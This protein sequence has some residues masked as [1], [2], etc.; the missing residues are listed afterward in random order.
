MSDP[1]SKNAVK[2][3][4]D[5]D[6]EEPLQAYLAQ[7]PFWLEFPAAIEARFLLRG[8]PARLKRFLF[9]LRWS[10][11]V[12]TVMVL[13]D[14]LLLGTNKEW[15]FGLRLFALGSCA[16]GLLVLPRERFAAHRERSM[17]ALCVVMAVCQ[18][19]IVYAG[20]GMATQLYDGAL[21][22]V[23][24]LCN[25]VARVRLRQALP[26]TLMWWLLF[27]FQELFHAESSW[28]EVFSGGVFAAVIAAMSLSAKRAMELDNRATFA[29]KSLNAINADKLA[30]ANAE[31]LALVHFDP[32]TQLAN[33]RHCGEYYERMLR[34]AVR[35]RTPL[36]VLFVDIDYFKRFNDTYGHHAGDDCL[37]FVATMVRYAARRPLDLAVRYG[38]EEFVVILAG[39]DQHDAIRIAEDLCS[40]IYQVRLPHETHP[41]GRVT[42]S[43]GVCAG[44]PDAATA[45]SNLLNTADR[46]LY[47]AK[48]DGRNRVAFIPLGAPATSVE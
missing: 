1:T 13:C 30:H 18:V 16:A 5:R 44:R 43:I 25:Q 34:N 33:R 32:L 24:L 29:L 3:P 45:S 35:E 48:Q 38:G 9:C 15:A 36:A 28:R 31:L 21:V 10:L 40:Q 17:A 41:L 39:T 6:W 23:L 46:A 7:P 37:C 47:Q 42:V 26:F 20:D 4:P 14:G 11:A 27:V 22:L 19:L 12:L 8:R 2:A